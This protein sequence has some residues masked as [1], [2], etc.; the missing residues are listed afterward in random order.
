M[1][2]K[3]LLYLN[4]A[5][6]DEDVSLGFA[7]TWVKQF[8]NKFENIDIITLNKSNANLILFADEKFNITGLKKHISNSEYSY[9]S[10]ILKKK[11]TKKK[12]V[13]FFNGKIDVIVSDMAADTTGNK[14]LD[15]IR[16]N[17]LCAEA[18]NFSSKILKKDGKFIDF[19]ISD[20]GAIYE[21]L[22]DGFDN[23]DTDEEC[24]GNLRCGSDG[25]G[26][27]ANCSF[28]GINGII[29]SGATCCEL[30]SDLD[31]IPDTEDAC[32]N[33]RPLAWI[34]EQPDHDGDGTIDSVELENGT[35]PC[36]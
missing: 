5:L 6:D 14:S 7:N 30:D 11:D 18:I 4:L 17:Q 12:I 27:G 9:I 36:R 24:A 23:C 2:N 19:C 32:P 15:S 20:Y 31:G 13:D 28:D 10:D 34:L 29:R 35:N 3:N 22:F 16:T 1:N 21:L 25:G 33:K 26:V 8:S